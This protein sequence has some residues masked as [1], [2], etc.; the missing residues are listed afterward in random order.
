ML[1]AKGLQQWEFLS[2]QLSIELDTDEWQ[3]G[4]PSAKMKKPCKGHVWPF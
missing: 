2:Q 4:R 1:C 3:A